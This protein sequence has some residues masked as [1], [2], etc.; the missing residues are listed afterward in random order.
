M[1]FIDLHGGLGR[2]FGSIGLSLEEPTTIACVRKSSEFEAVGA[3]AERALSYARL[4]AEALG[5]ETGVSIK[6][7]A[8]IPEHAGLGSGTQCA[9]AVGMATAH[10]YGYNPTTREIAAIVQRGKRSG[11]GVAA[12]ELGGLLVDGGLGEHTEVPPLLARMD[13][14]QQ[15]DVLLVMDNQSSGVHGEQESRAFMELPP[16]PASYSAAIAR[17]VLMK[18]LPGAA[19]RD[20]EAFGTGIREI[21]QILGEHFSPAQGGDIYSSPQVARAMNFLE[22]RGVGCVGQSSWGPT[23][24]AILESGEKT[25]KLI[26]EV[27]MMLPGLEFRICKA[28]N[29]GSVIRQEVSADETALA[30]S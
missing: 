13:F 24:F 20:L 30:K 16:F 28:R 22:S 4:V 2:R 26:D 21:Q 23:G 9:L 8:A 15:W 1:G 17:L 18:I 19:E 10:A 6:M 5:V 27:R 11:I 14:P 25:L 29:Q 12:F 7:L 3:G